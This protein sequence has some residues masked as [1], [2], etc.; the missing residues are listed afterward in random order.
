[1]EY[2]NKV[3]K[4]GTFEVTMDGKTSTGRERSRWFL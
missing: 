1:M 3:E 2:V 4:W